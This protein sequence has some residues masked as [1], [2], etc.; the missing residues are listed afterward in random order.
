[1]NITRE[2]VSELEQIIKI[3]VA[4]NDYAERVQK[5]L[6]TYR[7]KATIPGFRKG[8]APLS[9]I[10]HMYKSAVVG[11]EVENLLGE[12][13][14]KY[15]ENEKLDILGGPLNNEEK[16]GV[17]DFAKNKDFVFY[18]D[19]AEAPKLK[20]DW[21]KIDT[22]VYQIKVSA[23]D[24]K[25]QVEEIS[26]RYGKFET[27]E[28]A[29]KGDYVYGRAVELDKSG[30]EK[31]GG[32]QAFTSFDLNGM[33]DEEQ[34]K[35]FLG[36]KNE[37][38]VVFTPSKAFSTSDLQHHFHIDEAAA[39]KF[40]SNVEFTISG[41]SHI[42]PHA[43][44]D[45][46]FKTVFPDEDIKD[47]AAFKKRLQKEMEASNEEQSHILYVNTLRKELLNQ[48]NSPLPEVFLKRWILS[49]G[50]KDVTADIIDNEW[51]EKYVPSIKYEIIDA[52]LS[53]IKPLNPTRDQ[54]TSYIK[55][56]LLKKDRGQEGEDEEAKAARIE[57]LAQSI[58]S[59]P[60]NTR[61]IINRLYVENTYE[62]LKGQLNPEVEKVSYKEFGEL[63]SK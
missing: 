15:I 16:T 51:T 46:L 33:K 30:A 2:K 11:E 8:M 6:K 20:I 13:L 35:L 50:A 34:C 54:I 32:I 40:K 36:K 41:I 28:V 25:E 18:Y 55:D 60:N 19:V 49:R 31:E 52:E 26:R 48:F 59:D 22:K 53:K 42:T 62:V 38:K 10:E 43:V 14:Y 37:E 17:I 12:S 24:V 47:E 21:N 1:M 4:E 56:I 3:E 45:E 58:A 57:Q 23:K 27:P 29:G 61:Q 7:Q 9:L 39:K 63:A 44:D 5:Q